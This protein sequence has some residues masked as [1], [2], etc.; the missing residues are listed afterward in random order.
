MNY[1]PDNSEWYEKMEVRPP[2]TAIHGTEDDIKAH[3]KPVK[4][5]NWKL[6]GNRLSC[7]T[8]LGKLVQTIPT[9]RIL[10]GEDERGLP[11]L[12]KIL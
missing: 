6:E 5:W 3:L 10:V 1:K 2:S 11:I 8:E 9:D 12:R 4:M 7:D